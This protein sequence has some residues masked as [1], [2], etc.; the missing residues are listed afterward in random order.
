MFQ[1]VTNLTYRVHRFKTVYCR[2]EN[3]RLTEDS[4]RRK[5]VEMHMYEYPKGGN[6]LDPVNMV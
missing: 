2:P 4:K 3:S 5:I 1:R 6:Q